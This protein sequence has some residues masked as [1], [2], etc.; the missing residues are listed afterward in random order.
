MKQVTQR[1][2]QSFPTAVEDISGQWSPSCRGFS[3]LSMTWGRGFSSSH[4]IQEDRLIVPTG[5]QRGQQRTSEPRPPDCLVPLLTP[6]L[7]PHPRQLLPSN[8]TLPIP[9]A[10]QVVLANQ[11]QVF[12]Y[13]GERVSV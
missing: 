5:I 1:R 12:C 6:K 13:F 9:V 3:V 2:K 11:L 10:L 7:S 4:D 8:A